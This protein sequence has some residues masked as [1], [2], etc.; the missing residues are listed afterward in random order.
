MR[1]AT[2]PYFAIERFTL[3]WLAND[4][5]AVEFHSWTPTPEDPLKLRFARILLEAGPGELRPDAMRQSVLIMREFL[6]TLRL[7]AIPVLD[8]VGGVAL[9]VPFDD[10]P[11]YAPVRTWLHALANDAA[12]KYPQYFTTEPNSAGGARVHVHVKSNAPGLFSALPYSLRG[13][14]AATPSLRSHGMNS[15]HCSPANYASRPIVCKNG[16]KRSATF[17][18]RNST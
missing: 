9:F 2:H 12:A 18:N 11:E 1:R 3:D 7:C 15:R 14:I 6:A 4:W 17:S 8:G 16:C 5:A 10:A 13:P